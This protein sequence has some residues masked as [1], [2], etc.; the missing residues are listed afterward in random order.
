MQKR[1]VE[2]KFL[3]L[4]MKRFYPRHK[5]VKDLQIIAV[6]Q[7]ADILRKGLCAY[8]GGEKFA[9]LKSSIQQNVFFSA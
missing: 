7:F 6:L 9:L 4:T 3:L 5:N 2:K 1:R 8:R